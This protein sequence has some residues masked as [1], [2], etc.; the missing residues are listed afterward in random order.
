VAEAGLDL[1]EVVKDVGMIELDVVHDQQLGQVVDELRALIEERAV[2][3]VPLDHE[4]PRVIEVRALPEIL[5]DA[6]DHVARVEP[7]DAQQPR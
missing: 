4:M 6:A 7:G 2:V 3:F 1:L 5:R